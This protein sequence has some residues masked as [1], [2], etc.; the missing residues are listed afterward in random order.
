MGLI[1]GMAGHPSQPTHSS[2]THAP[3]HPHPPPPPP[4][5]LPPQVFPGFFKSRN[6]CLYKKFIFW[7]KTNFVNVHKFLSFRYRKIYFGCL[8]WSRMIPGTKYKVDVF[9]HFSIKIHIKPVFWSKAPILKVLYHS[10]PIKTDRTWFVV[11]GSLDIRSGSRLKWPFM[12][13]QGPTC[14]LLYWIFIKPI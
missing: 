8:R 1:I 2:R 9:K 7:S 10:K 13:K 12:Q 4:T 11:S 3:P 14:L 5:P 6:R